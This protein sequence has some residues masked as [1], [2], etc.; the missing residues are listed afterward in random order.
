MTSQ[1]GD[2]VNDPPSPN[3]LEGS[4]GVSKTRGVEVLVHVHD[5]LHG[6]K[7]HNFIGIITRV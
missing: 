4:D 1:S 7:V 2:V 5:K 6:L 3:A